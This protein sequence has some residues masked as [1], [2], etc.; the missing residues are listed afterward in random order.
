MRDDG[1]DNGGQVW[2]DTHIR[3]GLPRPGP[4]VLGLIIACT[5]MFLLTLGTGKFVSPLFIWLSLSLD[6]SYE[7][8]RFVTF[9]FMHANPSHFLWNMVGLYFFGPPLEQHWGWRRFLAFYL[10]CGVFAGLCFGG[11]VYT[12]SMPPQ[13]PI[14][15]ASGGIMATLMGCAILF[16]EMII[17]VFPVRW[18][19]GFYFVLYILNILYEQS[20]ADAAHLGGM[21][22]AGAWI[23][24]A[25]RVVSTFGQIRRQGKQGKW[26]KKIQQR[27]QEQDRIDAILKKVHEQ[28]INSLTRKERDE[29]Q[30]ASRKQQDDDRRIDRM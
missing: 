20:V 17:I 26:D 5:V 13:M 4:A 8:W 15:G 1:R 6:K 27:A 19:A 18:V 28:G 9:Q 24:A 7:V 23:L 30:N 25:P 12:F 2:S 21:V 3:L 22:A 14:V 29:L 16:S 11:I 10:T